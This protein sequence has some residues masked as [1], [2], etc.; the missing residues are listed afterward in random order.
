MNKKRIGTVTAVLLLVAALGG[1]QL[2]VSKSDSQTAND[3]TISL[4][5]FTLLDL[6]GSPQA[7]DQWQN[8]VLLVNF[9]ATWCPP[10]QKEMPLL[11]DYQEKYAAQGLQVVAIAIDDPL[12]VQ[13]FVDIYDI[14]F[15][16]L[17]GSLDAI[18]LA[19]TLGNRFDSL[20]FTAIFD[21]EGN[22]HYIQAGEITDETLKKALLPLL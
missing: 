16:V 3:K 10:C 7:S 4:P 15:P 8:K 20:P 14:N 5:P 22:R 17:I 19:N 6:E 18:K 11:V 21:R 9:W 12:M 2:F 1:W 13:D